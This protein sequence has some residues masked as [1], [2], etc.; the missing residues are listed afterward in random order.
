MI[1]ATLCIFLPAVACSAA[2]VNR[3]IDDL[4]G[5]SSTGFI[6]TY[7]P[8]GNAW[9]NGSTCT[10]CNIY[11]AYLG[12]YPATSGGGVAVDISQVFDTTW[13]DALFHPGQQP[14]SFIVRFSGQAVYVFNTIANV[15]A[16]TTTATNLVFTLDGAAVGYYEHI[17][18][19]NGPELIYQVPV[20]VNESLRDGN[21][22][23]VV[24]AQNTTTQSVI[25]FDYIIYTVVDALVEGTTSACFTDQTSNF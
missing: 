1:L 22:T 16:K 4:Y 11:P 20:Y 10:I 12:H 9:K 7:L 25:L 19:P 14:P 24:S 6:P 13:H 2:L 15:V 3:T 5:D 18:D 8:P 17:P 23:L 21:H